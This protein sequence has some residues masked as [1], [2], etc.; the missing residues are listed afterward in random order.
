MEIAIKNKD[1]KWLEKNGA[2]WNEWAIRYAAMKGHLEI[3][4]WLRENGAPWNEWA[5]SDAAENGHLDIVKWLREHG[6]P[7]DKWAIGYAAW[8][9]HLEIVKWLREHG[10]PWDEYA[11]NYAVE[12]GHLEIVKWLLLNG[13]YKQSSLT[14]PTIQKV[15][16]EIEQEKE[17]IKIFKIAYAL[18]KLPYF[19]SADIV[20][21][22]SLTY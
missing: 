20:R 10:A 4:K 5:I 2:P 8:K 22:I 3:V 18:N 1:M 17:S 7:W 16:Q 6:A 19:I 21:N 11:I 15:Y 13:L 9:G 14:K 12:Y